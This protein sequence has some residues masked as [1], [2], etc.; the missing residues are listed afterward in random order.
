MSL[1]TLASNGQT[2]WTII[3]PPSPI[4]SERYAAEELSS[5]LHTITDAL[6]QIAE[7]PIQEGHQILLCI[8]DSMDKEE[9]SIRTEGESLIL[10]GG[11][12]RGV[13]YAVYELLDKVFGCRWFTPEVS[14]IPKRRFLELPPLDLHKKPALSYREDYNRCAFE[15]TWAA[16][17]RL[18]G[19]VNRVLEKHGGTIRYNRPSGGAHSF[20]LLVPVEEYFDSHPEYFSEVNGVRIKDH[21]QLCLTNPDVIEISKRRVLS[22][23]RQDPEAELIAV[24]QND[25]YNPCQCPACRAIDEQEGTHAGTLITFV[26]QIAEAVAAEYPDKK[27]GVL[28]YQYTR[29]PPKT[30]RVHPNVVIRLCSIECCF[31][32]PLRSCREIM[33]FR[34]R[35][36]SSSS[37]VDDLKGW[38]RICDTIHIWDYTTDFMHYLMP[39][40]NFHVL[41]DNINFFIE[42]HAAGIFEQGNGDS[43]GGELQ[44][45]RS[46]LIARLLWNPD[47]DTDQEM[48]EFL[49][50]FY[51][52][53]SS[54]IYRYIRLMRKKVVDENIHMGIY[55]PP[56]VAY[57]SEDILSQAEALLA[58]AERLADDEVILERVKKLSLS[59]FYTRVARLPKDAPDRAQKV[60][61]LFRAVD[62]FGI[63]RIR[64]L[65]DNATMRRLFDECPDDLHYHQ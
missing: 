13:L 19:P 47:L 1:L 5:I 51:G 50:A 15:G 44:E 21:T 36:E 25:W 65:R 59:L 57:L 9:F 30:L 12:P 32:H 46:Y 22:W 49:T 24:A 45:L 17:N 6:F 40:P 52:Q 34:G 35:T 42:N 43:M 55:G 11:R 48:I 41:K 4:P 16:R 20:G 14:H 64:E 38:A 7:D 10:T 28:A 58:E 56:T 2:D 31:T 27:L 3:L 29:K 62:R 26:N 54:P 39:F 61:D 33:S 63:R 8:D 23:I 60:E 18:N 53:A 37:F